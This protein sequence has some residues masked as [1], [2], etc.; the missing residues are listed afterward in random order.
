ML[1]EARA[2]GSLEARALAREA[3]KKSERRRVTTRRTSERKL[4]RL[5]LCNA[6]SRTCWAS[7]LEAAGASLNASPKGKIIYE[8]ITAYVKKA[9]VPV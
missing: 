8:G 7:M 2:L 6:G 9:T 4:R 1:A 5:A 3:F